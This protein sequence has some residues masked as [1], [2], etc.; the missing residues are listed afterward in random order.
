MIKVNSKSF[1]KTI[2][3]IS[4]LLMVL[5]VT[6]YFIFYLPKERSE[7]EYLSNQIKCKTEGNKLHKQKAEEDSVLRDYYDPQFKFNKK[8]GVCLYK[9]GYMSKLGDNE[10]SFL[11]NVYE[12]KVIARYGVAVRNGEWVDYI[13]SEQEWNKK[14]KELLEE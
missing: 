2:L 3:L 7:K 4:I 12:N 8:L 9:S 1:L 10:V 13:S 11:V 14:V 5:A 6:Y